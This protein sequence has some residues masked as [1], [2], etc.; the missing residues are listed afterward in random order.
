MGLCYIGGFSRV[1][2]SLL[3]LMKLQWMCAS[4]RFSGSLS[5]PLATGIIWSTD[6]RMVF[7]N[8]RVMSTLVEHM[9]HVVPSLSA[10]SVTDIWWGST[11]DFLHG[12]QNFVSARF[13][14]PLLP[15]TVKS[16]KPVHLTHC[17]ILSGGVPPFRE[18]SCRHFSEHTF[19]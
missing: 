8:S 4:C 2:P 7:G 18:S 6:A 1:K 16:M 17:L 10:S 19:R 15:V 3:F 5:P 14:R 11:L 12:S 9:P 13:L